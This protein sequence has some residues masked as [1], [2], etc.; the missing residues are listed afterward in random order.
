MVGYH[1]IVM[2]S[3]MMGDY[4]V[5]FCESVMV[6]FRRATRPR[7]IR[8]FCELYETYFKSGEKELWA[9]DRESG[10]VLLAQPDG[11]GKGMSKMT[12]SGP[13]RRQRPALPGFERIV[14]FY[15]L[16]L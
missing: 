4:Q 11:P 2:K 10:G 15:T 13:I 5:R 16:S 6:R 3:R 9:G 8:H 7:S 12:D 1:K 14:D